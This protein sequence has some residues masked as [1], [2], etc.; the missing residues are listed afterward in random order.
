M[1]IFR[2]ETHQVRVGHAVIGGNHDITVQSM[3]NTDTKDIYS[4]SVQIRQLVSAGCDI[5]RIG[6]YDIECVEAFRQ[7]R[8]AFHEVPLV[9][10]VHFD[11]K[12]AL[13]AI[14]E[15]I[16]K[17]RLNP[18]NIDAEWKIREIVIAARE[19]GIPIRVGANSGSI[20]KRFQKL[21]RVDALVE[22]A[23]EQARLLEKNG[24]EDIVI[25]VKSSAP[26]ETIQANEQ[27]SNKTQ[28]PLHLGVTEAGPLR[29][30]LVKSSIA[31]SNLLLKG[32][33]DTL[34]YSISGD[35][36][37]EVLAGHQLLI[38][39]GLREGINLVSCPTCARTEIDLDDYTSRVNEM[40]QGIKKPL[41]IAIM[42]C[43]VN[44][45]GEGKYADL[46]IAGT[47]NGGVIFKKGEIFGKFNHEDLFVV[48]E[49]E[50]KKIIN[51]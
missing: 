8:K 44:G 39:L 46:G 42:G 20:N 41:T 14:K 37:E 17:I 3:T 40:I 13:K 10:D 29:Q 23:L 36:V 22:S 27:L 48:F 34:R 43:V 50:L 11:Y 45:M 32:I 25:A 7:V 4:T 31:L 35:P 47:K 24:F 30:S 6:L 18:G 51:E 21:S 2:K 19:K 1:S 26:L 9:G 38:S 5:I 15:G 49:K 33:G 16:D 12:I 28:H